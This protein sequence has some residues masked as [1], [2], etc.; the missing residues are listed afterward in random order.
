MPKK[1]TPN[2]YPPGSRVAV[3]LPLPIGGTYDY[4]VGELMT[5]TE[6]DFVSVPLGPR[7]AIGVIWGPATGEVP[8]FKLKNITTRLDCPP[9]PEVSRQ[10]INWTANYTL[11][12]T[13]LILKMAIRLLAIKSL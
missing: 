13:G 6:G 4:Q 7:K 5:V 10:F 1:T 2:S 8:A 3:Q 9:L 12:A 11:Q